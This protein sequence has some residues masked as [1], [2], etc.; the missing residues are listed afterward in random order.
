M[1]ADSTPYV[2]MVG[3]GN[4]ESRRATSFPFNL[5]G[6]AVAIEAGTQTSRR[7]TS[8]KLLT[9]ATA[10]SRP[11]DYL[12]EKQSNRDWQGLRGIAINA[13]SRTAS[14][15]RCDAKI[16]QTRGFLRQAKHVTCMPVNRIVLIQP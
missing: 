2:V 8:Q 7:D 13:R 3:S 10:D 1:E 12:C 15:G 6:N 9:R 4:T 16:L 11:Q 5:A 14:R